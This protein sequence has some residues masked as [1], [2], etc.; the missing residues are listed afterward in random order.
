MAYSAPSR[1]N[2][3]DYIATL[4]TV[5]VE[6]EIQPDPTFLEDD[7]AMFTN[8]N[9]FDFDLG[10]DADLQPVDYTVDGRRDHTIAPDSVDMKP[11]EFLN[12]GDFHFPDF[13][14]F[15][16]TTFTDTTLPPAPIQTNLHLYTSSP[17]ASSPL[18]QPFL[19]ISTPTRTSTKRKSDSISAGSPTENSEDAARNAAEED[20]RRRNTAASARFRVKKKQREQALEQSAKAMS[21]KVSA[22]E[23]RINQLET[24]NKWLKNLITEKNDS[25]EDIA[26][27]WKKFSAGNAERI[28]PE[29][30]DGV[31]T[32]A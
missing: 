5:P 11:L 26:T 25:K 12:G 10:Q 7:L 31:G 21:D 29:R 17:E 1:V 27:L 3:V 18:A 8:T 4:N 23:G 2:M 6:G 13:N 28:H 32:Q 20:K 9:F 14:S 15:P 16:P 24:E 19:A 30:K 22:L